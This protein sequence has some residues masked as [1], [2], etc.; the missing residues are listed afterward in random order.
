MKHLVKLTS[1]Q[2]TLA[3]LSPSIRHLVVYQVHRRVRGCINHRSSTSPF[4]K[5]NTKTTFAFQGS[6]QRTPGYRH[7]GYDYSRYAFQSIKSPKALSS[8]LL[9]TTAA[10]CL[11]IP[12]DLMI[13][14]RTSLSLVFM[15]PYLQNGFPNPYYCLQTLYL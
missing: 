13:R 1:N 12:P 15:M 8:G 5:R 2:Q 11:M 7:V 6:S 14:G 9:V 10:C 3:I 4:K